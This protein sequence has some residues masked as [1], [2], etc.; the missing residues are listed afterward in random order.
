MA[1]LLECLIQIKALRDTLERTASFFRDAPAESERALVWTRMADAERRY[2]AALG[3]AAG[4]NACSGDEPD[5]VRRAFVALRHANLAALERCTASELAGAIVWPGRR[6][7][8][9]ADLVAIMLAHDTDV[10][11]ELRRWRSAPEGGAS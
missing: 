9:I 2:A 4:A 6:S 1:D 3:T 11:G 5:E 8:T 10:L 7:T